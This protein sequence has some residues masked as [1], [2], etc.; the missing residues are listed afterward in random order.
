MI[1]QIQ[2]FG[3]GSF[4]IHGA[5]LIYINPWRIPRPE[6]PADV[7]LIGGDRY[8]ECSQA[9]IDKLRAPHTRIV[10][11][12]RAAQQIDGCAA[13]LPWQ[14]ITLDRACIKAV[15][16]YD[17][18]IGQHSPATDGLGFV[19]S[20]SYYDLYY[21]GSTKPTPEMETLHPDIA[22]LPIS[23][24]MTL[25][26]AAAVVTRMRPRWVI[27]YNWGVTSGGTNRIDALRFQSEVGDAAEV[28]LLAP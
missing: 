5:P 18:E 9:D 28:L 15:P 22:L 20:V 4:V 12:E 3:Q 14:S 13:L 26:E 21:A 1:R 25:S 6:R 11:C 19:I 24:A 7:I 27:P 23:D 8:H 17:P 16:A 10:G 2:W